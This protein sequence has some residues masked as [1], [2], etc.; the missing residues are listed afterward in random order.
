M[1]LVGAMV[2]AD[3][4]AIAYRSRNQGRGVGRTGPA[5]RRGCSAPSRSTHGTRR[6]AGPG[7]GRRRR[8]PSGARPGRRRAGRPSSTRGTRPPGRTSRSCARPTA[9]RTCAREAAERAVA[10]ARYLAPELLNAAIV[11]DHLGTTSRRRLPCSRC[12]TQ[13]AT[14]FVAEWPRRV[15][16]GDG[17]IPDVTDPSW[18][19]NLLL[20]RDSAG[21]PIE[22]AEFADPAVR[23][24][25]YA[26]IGEREEAEQWLARAFEEHP[27]EARTHGRRRD[28]SRRLGRADRGRGPDRGG[29]PGPSIPCP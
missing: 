19:L 27:D 6:T 13:P 21:E 11:L 28:P 2:T 23:A 20:A 26:T 10:K 14:S 3:A 8:R 18:Q 9:T 17:R 15:A 5:R 16:I 1:V 24:L 4:G 12:S 29:R 25:A 7:R 22:P